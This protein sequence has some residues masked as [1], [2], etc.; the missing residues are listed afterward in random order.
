MRHKYENKDYKT[1]LRTCCAERTR[2]MLLA[3]CVHPILAPY[4]SSVFVLGKHG[5]ASMKKNTIIVTALLTVMLFGGCGNNN[6]VQESD[7]AINAVA[8]H[9]Y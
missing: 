8:E 9:R 2:A 3:A 4:F 1:A 7:S 5:G 6:N